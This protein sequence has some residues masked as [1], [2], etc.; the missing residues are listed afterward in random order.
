[1]KQA[2]MVVGREYAHRRSRVYYGRGDRVKLLKKGIIRNDRYGYPTKRADGV[3]V[4]W[5]RDNG[6]LGHER[7]VPSSHIVS[8]W[9]AEKARVKERDEAVEKQQAV[10]QKA[11]ER[12]TA[13]REALGLSDDYGSRKFTVDQLEHFGAL[14]SAARKVVN[15]GLDSEEVEDLREAIYTFDFR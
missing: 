3:R 12:L 11:A 5:V 1:M 6:D 4:A 8:T 10:N 14:L 9:A 2:D 13:A 15:G 7:D